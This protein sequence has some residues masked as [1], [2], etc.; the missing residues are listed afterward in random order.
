MKLDDPS[1]FTQFEVRFYGLT[2]VTACFVPTHINKLLLLAK[3]PEEVEKI[4]CNSEAELAALLNPGDEF[5]VC[6]TA[7][8]LMADVLSA[9]KVDFSVVCGINDIG[10]AHSYIQIGQNRYDPTHQG[11]GDECIP[12]PSEITDPPMYP[13]HSCDPFDRLNRTTN[14]EAQ[15]HGS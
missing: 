3:T 7:C 2:W 11:F 9:K 1:D 4:S 12:I 8:E 6:D 5:L 13:D 14:E 10:D 15:N